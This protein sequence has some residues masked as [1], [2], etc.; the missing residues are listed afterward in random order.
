M[1]MNGRLNI[2]AEKIND[3]VPSTHDLFEQGKIDEIVNIAKE[4]AEQGARYIDVNIG[5]RDPRLMV[6]L[7]KSIQGQITLPLSIDTPSYEIAELALK[8]YDPAK[9][10]GEKPILNSIGPKRLQMFDLLKIQPCKVIMIV[11]EKEDEGKAVVCTEAVHVVEAAHQM[12]AHAQK[13]NICNDNI[14]FD[15]SIA[16]ISTD[17]KGL[18]RMTVNAVESIGHTPLF[19]GCHMSVGLSN[20]TV[21]M[22]SKTKSGQLVKTPL[23]NAFLTLTVPKG[24]DHVIG[25]SKK[26]Y[27]FLPED[28]PAMQTVSKL[29]GLTG[30]E[31]LKTVR[32][33][34]NS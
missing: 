15:P 7:V 27:D 25:S 32:Q 29:L 14:I 11:N 30:M 3:S 2:I 13:H 17:M 20:F 21:M 24:L 10:G 34:Y 28:H 18:T 22:P 26:K 6:E 12:Y 5:P 1:A 16:P 33:F 4:Q 19:K 8:A 9:A 31:A 23:E